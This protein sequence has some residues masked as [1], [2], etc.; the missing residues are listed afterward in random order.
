MN[1]KELVE[2]LNKLDDDVCI[3]IIC[4]SK[5]IAIAE[6]N[7]YQKEVCYK[8]AEKN[9]SKEKKSKIICIDLDK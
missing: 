7:I 1:K 2:I 8:Y 3:E 4:D 6:Y 5:H 9:E